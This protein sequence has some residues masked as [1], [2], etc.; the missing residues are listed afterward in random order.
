MQEPLEIIAG[1]LTAWVAPIGTAF[2]LITAAPAGPWTMVGANG[3]RNYSDDGVSVMHSQTIQKVRPAGTVGAVK[4]FRTEE[5]LTLTL[6]LWDLTL[7]AYTLA[8]NGATVSATAAGVG[9]AGFKK[10]GLSRGEDVKTYALLVRGTKSAYGATYAAQYE[11]PRC[12]QSANPNPAYRKGVPA[13]LQLV[14]DALE[15]GAA[16]SADERF[17]RLIMQHQA[18]LA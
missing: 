5:D 7:E 16:T 6:T 12:Y 17:G 3:D 15:Y 4:A 9:T 11:V 2:P 8:L 13:G 10:L 1:P 14:F 18:P